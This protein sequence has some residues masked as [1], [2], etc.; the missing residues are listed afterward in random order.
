M[1]PFHK[2]D[3]QKP[4]RHLLSRPSGTLSSTQSE[5]EGWGEEALIGEATV[6]YSEMV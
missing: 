2:E 5:G 6:Y 1:I 4:S 3:R